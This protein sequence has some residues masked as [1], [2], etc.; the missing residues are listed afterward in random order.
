MPIGV[1]AINSWNKTAHSVGLFEDQRI[2]GAFA[3]MRPSPWHSFMQI[4]T[5]C[6]MILASIHTQTCT[7]FGKQQIMHAT[8]YTIAM[9]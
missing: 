9:E 7:Y 1:V 8:L 2:E 6:C 5:N 4:G 3:I